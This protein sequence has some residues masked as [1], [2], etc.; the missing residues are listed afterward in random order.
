[1][2]FES[3]SSTVIVDVESTILLPSPN[4]NP[5][6]SARASWWA[7]STCS[8]CGPNIY[9]SFSMSCVARGRLFK[10]KFKRAASASASASPQ[11]PSPPPVPTSAVSTLARFGGLPS[12]SH[13]PSPLQLNLTFTLTASASCHCVC[14]RRYAGPCKSSPRSK[15]LEV[16]T[17]SQAFDLL[18]VLLVLLLVASRLAFN[19]D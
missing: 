14:P 7:L 1:M 11:L 18:H 5:S 3:P 12:P 16:H 10:I 19:E 2:I 4:P 13:A 9:L 17:Q 15:S 6:A 8:R